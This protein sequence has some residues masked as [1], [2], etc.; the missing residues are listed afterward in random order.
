MTSDA[1]GRE[2]SSLLETIAV[3]LQ[4]NTAAI[5]EVR[6]WKQ[7]VFRVAITATIIAVLAFAATGWAF[8]QINQGKIA[9]CQRTNQLRAEGA[10]LWDFLVTI[11]KPPPHQTPAQARQRKVLIQKFL[12]KVHE[13]YAPTRCTGIFG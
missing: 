7:R 9:S 3:D 5:G 11:S 8:W 6:H 13:V 1:A 4:A 12:G 10:E 2:L